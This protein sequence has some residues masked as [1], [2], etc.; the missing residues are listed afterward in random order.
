[1]KRRAVL[2]GA[3][4]A[5]MS[6]ASP[7]GRAATVVLTDSGSIGGFTM[8]NTGIVGTTATIVISGQPNTT[9]QLNTVNGVSVPAELT[10]FS[11]P[12]TLLV[13]PVLLNS[14]SLALS[15]PTY[16]KTIGAVAGSQ[17]ELAYNLSTGATAAVLPAF[18]NAS[19]HVTSVMS[20]ANPLY[21]FSN[22]ANGLGTFN[23]TFTATSFGGGATSFDSLFTTVGATATGNGSFSQIATV[24][25]PASWA[26]LGI[27][28]TGFLAFRRYFKKTSVA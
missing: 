14:Y 17:A 1:M 4:L 3:A 23:V 13:T 15:P 24:P 27:G 12:I 6:L 22:F 11:G 25:E 20:N 16:T 26:L 10:T 5:L 8:T 9:S 7:A 19:G 2:L 18:F 21:D 28:M